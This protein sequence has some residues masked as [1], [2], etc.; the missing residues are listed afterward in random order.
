MLTINTS[1]ISL[2]VLNLQELNILTECLWSPINLGEH[3][4][5]V[6]GVSAAATVM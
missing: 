4:E 2:S 3:S 1:N 5:E 6:G